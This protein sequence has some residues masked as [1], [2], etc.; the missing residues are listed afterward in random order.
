MD[1]IY[2]DPV[3]RQVVDGCTVIIVPSN[4]SKPITIR[5]AFINVPASHPS[6]EN[7]MLKQYLHLPSGVVYT[8][9]LMSA[10]Y[11]RSLLTNPEYHYMYYCTRDSKIYKKLVCWIYAYNPADNFDVNLK[12]VEDGYACPFYHFSTPKEIFMAH[13][14]A[15]F[16]Y[17]GIFGT[18]YGNVF[19]KVCVF[20]Q[21]LGGK[22]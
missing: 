6:S 21:R 5:L 19:R 18:G 3:V 8:I 14:R 22:K 15:E 17:S 2:Y 10:K 13:K 16:T 9:G 11:L 4:N 1:E 12:M 20:Y 7:K